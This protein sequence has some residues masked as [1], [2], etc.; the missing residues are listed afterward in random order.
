MAVSIQ[1]IDTNPRTFVT[2]TSRYASSQVLL[3]G[4]DKITTFE[5]YK[6]EPFVNS[7]SDRFAVVPPGEE[8]RPDLTSY[9]AYGTVDYWWQILQANQIFDIYDYKSGLN[10]RIPTPFNKLLGG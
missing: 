6:R 7:D 4:D 5:T 9:R 1:S 3:Y 10:I 2:A 8:Y